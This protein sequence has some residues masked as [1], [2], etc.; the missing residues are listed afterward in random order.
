MEAALK[1]GNA[2][3]LLGA[4]FQSL[5]CC[6]LG[7]GL[8]WLAFFP[9]QAQAADDAWWGKDKRKHLLLSSGAAFAGYL[10]LGSMELE[11]AFR[12]GLTTLTVLGA[13]ALK[14][15]WDTGGRGQASWKDMAWNVVGNAVGL[16][17]AWVVERWLWPGR[18]KQHPLG[19]SF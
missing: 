13:G 6:M 19:V 18:Q 1:A 4:G 2:G 3:R 17:L 7:V 10:W 5:F 8:L 15:A 14:E 12:I 16:L 9:R 11:P